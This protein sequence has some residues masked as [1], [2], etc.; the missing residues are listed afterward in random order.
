[1]KLFTA[2]GQSYFETNPIHE[3]ID[4]NPFTELIVDINHRYFEDMHLLTIV[5]GS[6]NSMANI[7]KCSKGNIFRPAEI[8]KDIRLLYKKSEAANS[9]VSS[10][11][12]THGFF[13]KPQ[14]NEIGNMLKVISSINPRS[15]LMIMFMD[16][17]DENAKKILLEAYQKFKML[18]VAIFMVNDERQNGQL[19]KTILRLLLHN[20]Y[21]RNP[22]FMSFDFTI[23]NVAKHFATINSFIKMRVRNLQEFSLRVSIFETPM[24]CKAVYDKNKKLSHFT[25]VEGE[26]LLILSK[27]MNFTPIYDRLHEDQS[28]KFG[29]QYPNGT[30]TGSLADVEYGYAD[31]AMNAKLITD[32]Y[33]TSKSIFLQ[34][35]TMSRL[36]FI[37]RK[38]PT[39]KMLMIAIFTL[40]DTPSRIIAMTLSFLFPPIY[41]LINRC[42]HRIIDSTKRSASFVKS[43]LLAFA[44]LNNV[45]MR[46]SPYTSSR[47]IV[48]SILF[49][50][51]VVSTLFQSTIVRNLN[52]NKR[53]GKITTIRQLTDEGF[54]LQTPSYIALIFKTPGVD[55]VSLMMQRANQTYL[56]IAVP[57]S[58]LTSVIKP[59][60]KIAFLWNDL[61]VTNYLNQFY[62]RKS[63]ENLFENVPE[64]AFEF[65]VAQ[66]APK[67]SPFIERFNEILLQ[68][69]ET[70]IGKYHV[71]RAEADND[72][73]WIQRVKNGEIALQSDGAIKLAD[74]MLAFEITLYLSAMSCLIFLL[75]ICVHIFFLILKRL[76]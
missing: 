60:K 36:S 14:K 43:F 37:I 4:C 59:G 29:F 19:L 75:E 51:L 24:I 2:F 1:M 11:A 17:E 69:T 58:N 76:Y 72:K 55:K 62:G 27:M 28:S 39:H 15:K 71:G 12:T 13:I 41:S 26:L 50:T 31:L 22:Q 34:P 56:D 23:S 64:I 9:G 73:I 30:F 40:Y 46:Q 33:N 68:F 57:S 74:L 18:N 65:Y 8:Y 52:T 54:S 42:E 63:G 48:A 25:Y 49:Y 67:S 6:E 53:L 66:M 7:F 3:D 32:G 38:R 16:Y 35:I 70:G 5:D 61:Y 21:L 45:S 10:Y 47:I 44:I 20:P